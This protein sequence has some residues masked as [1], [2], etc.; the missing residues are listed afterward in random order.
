MTF[1]M[2]LSTAFSVD[3]LI[4]S[5]LT[6]VLLECQH[7]QHIRIVF[8]SQLFF[9]RRLPSDGFC[10]HLVCAVLPL[11][12]A[13]QTSAAFFTDLLAAFLARACLTAL[14]ATFLAGAFLAAVFFTAFLA[15]AFFAS[16]LVGLFLA[17]A[18]LV[19]LFLATAFFTA[20][21]AGAFFAGTFFGTVFLRLS[22][23][24]PFSLLSSRELSSRSSTQAF[25][26]TSVTVLTA[27]P[28]A[29]FDGASHVRHRRNSKPDRE[30]S[31]VYYRFLAPFPA[32]LVRSYEL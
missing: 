7:L 22:W 21:F 14:L 1:S 20:F 10:G 8:A 9:T 13:G 19:G 16:F 32:S 29:R 24:E 18:F 15:G 6:L 5:L 17:T 26:R 31:F 4:S 12:A 25:F 23:P 11:T 3:F 28:I 2:A 30:P 27:W